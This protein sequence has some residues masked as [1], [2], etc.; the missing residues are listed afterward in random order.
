MGGEKE[1]GDERMNESFAG[2]PIDGAELTPRCCHRTPL[3]LQYEGSQGDK[4]LYRCVD[5]GAEYLL[6][7]APANSSRASH[8]LTQERKKT[9]Y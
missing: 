2:E 4:T 6:K 3:R 7:S 1:K 5:C 9:E 8:G